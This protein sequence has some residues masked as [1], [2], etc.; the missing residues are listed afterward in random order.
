MYSFIRICSLVLSLTQGLPSKKSHENPSATFSAI[1][2]P[3][4]LTIANVYDKI[5]KQDFVHVMYEFHQLY[6]THKLTNQPNAKPP[7]ADLGMF[8]MLSRT[9]ATTKRGPHKRSG[10]FF[11][12]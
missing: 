7:A 2:L 8:S 11:A 9:G 10:N 6:M 5:I 3:D 4:G 1:L 12:T